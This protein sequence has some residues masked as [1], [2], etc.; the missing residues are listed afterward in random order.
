MTRRFTRPGRDRIAR[1]EITASR[2]ERSSTWAALT[3]RR[4]G[5]SESAGRPSRQRSSAGP[6]ASHHDPFLVLVSIAVG[7]FASTRARLDRALHARLVNARL[8]GCCADPWRW[9]RHLEHAFRRHARVRLPVPGSTSLVRAAI[10]TRGGARL[11]PG[12]LHC[13][14]HVPAVG[15]IVGRAADGR[16][17]QWQPTSAWRRCGRG[18]SV[19]CGLVVASIV[20]AVTTS[21]VALLLAFRLRDAGRGASVA[22]FV[23]RDRHGIAISGMH[24]TGMAAARFSD[25]RVAATRHVTVHSTG[26]AIAVITSTILI[27][28]LALAAAAF[29]ERTRLLT[30]EQRARHDAEVASRL[31]DE[32]LATLSHELRT[33]LNVIVGRTQMLHSIA[34]DP[35]KVR[36]AAETI[37]RNGEALT[38]MVEDLLDVSR[39]TLGRVELEWRRVD[40]AGW[41]M[42]PRRESVRP[43]KPRASAASSSGSPD[44]RILGDQTGAAGGVEPA[45]HAVKF[46]PQGGEVR[47]EI[48]ND[49]STWSWWSAIAAGNRSAFVPSFRHVRKADSALIGPTAAWALAFH[50]PPAGRAARA[51]R[52][53]A[54]PEPVAAPHSGGA[55]RL[56]AAPPTPWAGRPAHG[57]ARRPLPPESHQPIG[58]DSAAGDWG[59]ANAEAQQLVLLIS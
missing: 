23:R 50:R 35:E 38:R 46:K 44:P 24:Y 12:A 56:P 26:L 9:R 25:S 53:A 51:A 57:I 6:Y 14:P 13:Q 47:T 1:G 45:H 22:A 27:L 15:R 7:I 58:P 4:C 33:P 17:D 21:S 11:R 5:S 29:D 16:S 2:T 43:P 40:F 52:V 42:R 28:S 59:L 18:L 10:R 36:H 37:S 48:R 3:R 55:L 31:K 20:I 41:S 30:R 8:V 34:D 49:G 19:A 54:S 39:I 32:F